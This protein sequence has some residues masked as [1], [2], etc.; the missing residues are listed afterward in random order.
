MTAAAVVAA[1]LAS[2]APAPA[3]P[4]FQ[5][6]PAS[7]PCGAGPGGTE[8]L[9]VSVT[10]SLEADSAGALG[11]A[12]M[13]VH[14]RGPG[15]MAF[16][17]TRAG[18][19]DALAAAGVP[20]EVSADCT[21]TRHDVPNDPGFASQWYL[22][23]VNAPAAWDRT[24]GSPSVVVAVVDSGIDGTH[25]DLSGKLAPGYDAVRGVPL[26]PGNTDGS[27]HGTAVAG[28][29]AAA[30]GNGGGLASL[31]WDTRVVAVKDGDAA[32]VRSA[33]VAGIRWAADS[34]ARVINVSSSYATF[35]PNE[36]DAVAYARARGSL[37][38]VSA[39][40]RPDGGGSAVVYPAALDGVLAVG[41]TGFDGTPAG[42]SNP[43]DHLDLVAPGGDEADTTRG[44][45]VLAPG[46]GTSFRAGTSYSAPLVAAAA[47]LLLGARPALGAGEVATLLTSSATDLGPPGRDAESGAGRLDVDAALAAA[48][49]PRREPRRAVGYHL[50]A[51]DGGIFAFGDARF[52]GSTGGLRLNRPIVGMS[53][54][55]SGNGYWLVASDGGIFAFGDAVFRGSTGA[56]TLAR[57]V[58]GMAPTPSG[59]G[60][61]LVASD[62]GIFAFGD[63]VFRGSTGALTLARPVV[64]MAPTPSGNGYWLVA[65][66]GGIFAFGDAVFRGST[67]AFTLA[68]PVVGMAA[69]R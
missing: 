56:L 3:A 5:P 68:R 31:G 6:A 34:G 7:E 13:T 43:G 21:G 51:S 45:H 39:G 57:P 49:V 19:R 15:V 52:L 40:E 32:P 54:T 36:A 35:D 12:G 60:Y 16:K 37:V 11:A 4:A 24:H 27:G 48:G 58:V 46:G 18:A 28:V 63:A 33:T 65:S 69:A 55:P 59:N 66:D 14:R 44:I 62:G 47:A 25:F 42:Y 41:A 29:V 64:G 9:Y 61:W 22:T 8:R 50:V 10:P 53:P 23:A 67:G 17:G 30:T 26:P 20:A 2:L 1:A 38:V